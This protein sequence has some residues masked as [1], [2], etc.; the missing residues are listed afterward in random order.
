MNRRKASKKRGRG[1]FNSKPGILGAC[2]VLCLGLAYVVISLVSSINDVENMSRAEEKSATNAPVTQIVSTVTPAYTD[3]ATIAPTPSPMPTFTPTPTP[4]PTPSPTPTPTPSP[5]P[6]PTPVALKFPYYIEIDKSKQVVSIYTI[7]SEGY[8]DLLVT[9]FI[10]STGR[11]DKIV[12][13]MYVI[14][15]QYRWRQMENDSYAQYA[16]RISGPYLMHSLCYRSQSPSKLRQSYY[17]RLGRNVSSGCVRLLAGDAY[18]IYTNCPVGTPIHVI[19]SGE[20]DEELLQKLQP[21]PLKGS[22]DPTDPDPKNP[23]FVTPSPDATPLPTPALGVTPAPT[24]MWT[25]SPELRAWG[26]G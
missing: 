16:S 20:K 14:Q 25:I 2:S 24:P 19:T 1:I 9:Q 12:D 6:E 5:T 8:Y 23:Y 17:S 10:C 21:P 3:E 4:T 13:G 7:G 15:E 18:W 22:W 26:Y 11:S